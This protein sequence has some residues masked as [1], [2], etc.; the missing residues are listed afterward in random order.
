MGVRSGSAGSWFAAL[1]V[2]L[3]ATSAAAQS[4]TIS[5][6]GMRTEKRVAL[7]IGNA[8]YA[9]PADLRNPLNDARDMAQALRGLGFD[10]ILSTNADIRGMQRAVR[11]FGDR[12]K[13]DGVGLFY[14]AGHGVQVKGTNY[15]VPIGARITRENE[16]EDEA[17]DVNRV[18]SVMADSRSRVSIVILDACRDNPF[19]RSFRSTTASGWLSAT[20]S[21]WSMPGPAE[22]VCCA[23]TNAR[24]AVMSRL[25]A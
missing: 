22:A 14:Y 8:S 17:V 6:E 12:L 16:V 18:L 20:A 10:V 1:L 19:A 9:A 5:V 21:G 7:V 3:A 11:D 23:H 13:P 25:E 24:R 15:L 2:L 4:R